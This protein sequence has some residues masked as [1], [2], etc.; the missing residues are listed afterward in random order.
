M[1]YGDIVVGLVRPERRNIGLYT[2]EL[3]GVYGSPDGVAVIRQR[4]G[5]A[6]NYPIEWLFQ[7]LRTE[8]CRIQFWTESGGTSYGKL[9]LDQIRDVLIQVPDQETINEIA[10]KVR[11]W[12]HAV[13]NVAKQFNKIWSEQDRIVILN[14]PITGLEGGGIPAGNN[15][16]DDEN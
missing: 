5:H 3:E 7:A 2:Y 16:G 12:S 1:H 10:N 14:S 9:T 11:S 8:R 4:P 6:N 15:D 13:A